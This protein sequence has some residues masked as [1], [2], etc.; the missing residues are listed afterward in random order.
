MFKGAYINRHIKRRDDER[1]MD[2]HRFNLTHVRPITG[3]IDNVEGI[4]INNK[5]GEMQK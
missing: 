2:H 3:T 4:T 5:K 1:T